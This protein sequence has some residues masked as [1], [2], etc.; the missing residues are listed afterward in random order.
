[1]I[2]N[3]SILK[4]ILVA[5][6]G[7]PEY[8]DNS[9]DTER[10]IVNIVGGD[11]SKYNEGEAQLLKRWLDAIG[12]TSVY[13]DNEDQTLGKILEKYGGGLGYFLNIPGKLN[14]ILNQINGTPPPPTPPT[15]SSS[16]VLEDGETL[17]ITL[18]EAVNGHT[19]FTLS[20]GFTATYLSGEGTAELL[21]TLSS[22]VASGPSPFNVSYSP[23]DVVS[24]SSATPLEAF[25]D[26]P[27][28]NGSTMD[29]DA[30][31]FIGRAS[32]TNTTQKSAVNELVLDLKDASIWTKIQALYPYVGGTAGSH[33]ENLKSSSYQIAWSGSVTHNANGI[34]GDGSSGYGLTQGLNASAVGQLMGLSN[35]MRNSDPAGFQRHI[36]VINTD[37]TSLWFMDCSTDLDQERGNL[38]DGGTGVDFTPIGLTGLIS[39]NRTALDAIAFY[40]EGVSIDT[41][42]LTI[43]V[44]PP[45]VEFAILGV[46]V[47]GAGVS[48]LC[49][50]NIALTAI[51]EGFTAGE[52]SDFNDAVVAYQTAL[53]RNV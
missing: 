49:R 21:F 34:T 40:N 41:G 31:D 18:S 19:G 16:T 30:I 8:D 27:A 13:A 38:G 17:R 6:G 12:G 26:F 9:V 1:M 20:G 29:A 36:G 25:S 28:A 43:T 15:Y 48:S 11:G 2:L 42:T 23:G 44:S 14:A 32:I 51:H 35:Y 22:I 7:N 24:V 45:A 3:T 46:N 37:F 52:E 47:E 39:V 53:G 33:A 50:E 5:L 10:K 4:Q